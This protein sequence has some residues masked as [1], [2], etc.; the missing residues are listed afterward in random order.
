M[1]SRRNSLR[2]SLASVTAGW[3]TAGSLTATAASPATPSSRPERPR[4]C[5]VLFMHGGPS[6]ID[7]W[8]P[9]PGRV[10]GGPFAAIPTAVP[11]VRVSEHLPRL[12]ARLDQLAV[13]RSLTSTE[14]N[15]D[16]ARYLMHTG[17]APAGGTAHP[18]LGAWVSEAARPTALPG[19]VAIGTPGHGAGFL[20]ATHGPFVVRDAERGV[21]TLEPTRPVTP[22]R[23]ADR[24]ALTAALDA[25]FARTRHDP[26]V[27]GH[28]A[29]MAQARD[30]MASPHVSAFELSNESAA[31]RE[32]YGRHAFGDGCLMARRLVEAGVSFV[33]VGL[34]GW[35]T[36]DDNF[37]RVR[38]LS[39]ML[40]TGMSALLD[41]LG[42]RGLLQDTLV[43]WIG[44]FGRSPQINARG[45]RDHYPRVSSAVLAGAG[46]PGGVVVGRTDDD[47]YEIA[48][49]PI[50]VPDLMRTAV[51][52]LGLDADA[53]RITPGG[54]PI[55]TVDGGR[56]IA[57]LGQGN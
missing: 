40:D 22:N 50:T 44:D 46:I 47:G 49:Q 15:H 39:A 6:Q 42:A 53:T 54:R 9:K 1:L 4:A 34:R 13:V 30:L 24:E 26:V 7:T 3:W 12:A 10:T 2:L 37:Q 25:D 57:G 5:I 41:D 48:E 51:S 18:G 17:Y 19:H 36:H 35:D 29:I 23:E 38:D 55:S 20:G 45:G 11:G 56:V 27:T 16:R 33:E 32:A 8:D 52:A 21:R 14:G 28:A 31:T 43:L